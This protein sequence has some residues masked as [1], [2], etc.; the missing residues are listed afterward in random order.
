MQ[1]KG[2]DYNVRQLK[3]RFTLDGTNF[4]IH[5]DTKDFYRWHKCPKVNKKVKMYVCPL[6]MDIYSEYEMKYGRYVLHETDFFLL[7]VLVAMFVIMLEMCVLL[8]ANLLIGMII[9]RYMVYL[10]MLD[11]NHF[12]REIYSAEV[13]VRSVLI[14]LII[15]LV[16]FRIGI[17][18]VVN[19]NVIE[20]KWG[21]YYESIK[22]RN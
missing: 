14:Y 3:I 5:T 1:E 15:S 16:I 22:V 9:F 19:K 7:M 20:L 4:Y 21:D 2:I 6:L 13:Y 17:M 12:Y 18:S 8:F 11:L 10:K